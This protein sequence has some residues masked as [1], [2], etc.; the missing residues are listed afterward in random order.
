MIK[1]ASASEL[2]AG[3]FA[4]RTKLKEAVD[5]W[6]RD[7]VAAK[8]THGPISGWDVSRVDDLSG[9]CYDE[10]KGCEDSCEGFFP[11]GFNGDIS[12]RS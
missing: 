3:A 10:M 5:E 7:A 12:I 4:D 8:A 2:P 11:I 6:V 1:S 9:C